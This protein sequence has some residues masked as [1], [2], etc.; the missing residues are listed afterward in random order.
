[1]AVRHFAD[2]SHRPQ[3]FERDLALLE[4]GFER[5]QDP[6]LRIRYGFYMARTLEDLGRYK[7]ALEWYEKRVR[8]KGGF[9]QEVFYSWYRMGICHLRLHNQTGATHAF[10]Q[11]IGQD[12]FRKEPYYYLARMNRV[13]QDYAKCILYGA[14]GMQMQ[15]PRQD[16]L[17]VE[18]V[19]YAWALQEEYATC[20]WYTGKKGDA[21]WHWTYLLEHADQLKIPKDARQRM[22]DNKGL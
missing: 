21:Q 7:H 2:G 13:T 15:Q 6:R 11:A 14:A 18:Q 19:I 1:M 9:H 5:E 4:S 8:W 20:L 12:P 16:A 22:R 3:K 10:V 17:F